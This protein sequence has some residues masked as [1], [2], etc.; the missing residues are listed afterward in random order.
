MSVAGILA[1]TTI[2]PNIPDILSD[3]GQPDSRAGLLVAVGPLPGV[4]VA[5][6]LG[7][8]ADRLGRRKVLLPCL[9]LFAV[10]GIGAAFSPTFG[11]LLV[12]RFLQ[13]LGSAG[14]ISL[15]IVM[16]GDHWTG[17]DRTRLIG[18]NSAVITV[19]L[20]LL[21]AISGGIAEIANWRWAIGLSSFG[22]VVAAIGA[23]RLP[24]VTP[25]RSRTVGEQISGAVAVIR[26]PL[27]LAVVVAGVVLFAVIFGVFLTTLPVHLEEQFGLG[28]GMRGLV[29]SVPAIGSTVAAFNLGRVRERWRIKPVLT[30]AGALVCFACLGVGLAP[31]IPIVLAASIIYGFGDGAG[32]ATLQ[33][34]ATSAAPDSQRASV[35]SAWVVAVRL[36]QGVG[37]LFFAALFAAT[38]TQTAMVVGAGLFAVLSVFFMFGPIDEAG[39]E[40]AAS[41]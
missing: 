34:V 6:I 27:V 25:D 31:T 23:Q 33:D 17:L 32:I 35:M 1:N 30:G 29:L 41:S 7:V 38:S 22:L 15:A 9:V 12:M 4:V 40:R 37:P 26:Q 13:G 39:V 21:P 11:V 16:I 2:T 20:A 8:L 36:G 10:S 14:L 19:C 5:P 28:P 3:L 18:R 24:A